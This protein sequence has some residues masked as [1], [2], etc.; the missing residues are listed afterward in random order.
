MRPKKQINILRSVITFISGCLLISSCSDSV[1]TETQN[2]K[3]GFYINTLCCQI[4]LFDENGNNLL[5]KDTPNNW[6]DRN[7]LFYSP[8]RNEGSLQP[9]YLEGLPFYGNVGEVD[10]FDELLAEAEEFVQKHDGVLPLEGNGRAPILLTNNYNF[11]STT[12]NPYVTEVMWER[13]NDS[14]FSF[15]IHGI[16][17][18]E[19]YLLYIDDDKT[20]PIT[21]DVEIVETENIHS[22]DYMGNS[23]NGVVCLLKDCS[24]DNHE[25][26]YRRG[27]FLEDVHSPRY[28]ATLSLHLK[29]EDFPRATQD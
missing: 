27:A 2:V 20:N 18:P 1:I 12:P 11:Y 16:Q 9:Y 21:F 10:N 14:D 4:Q 13:I 15:Y 23:L 29:T 6:L 28:I 22:L 3:D 24:V 25:W 19:K 26:V 17:S 8:D 5:S 7:F